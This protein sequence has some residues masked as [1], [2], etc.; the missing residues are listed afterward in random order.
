[1]R[2]PWTPVL[3]AAA[4]SQAW[5][6]QFAYPA[7]GQTPQQQKGDEAACDKGAVEQTGID[8]TRA[9]AACLEDR[10]YTRK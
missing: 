3:T 10:G 9:R 6:A 2:I 1:L 7:N 5:S 8:P 4:V